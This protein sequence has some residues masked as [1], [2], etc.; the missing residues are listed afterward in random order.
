[1]NIFEEINGLKDGL[2]DEVTNGRFMPDKGINNP[3]VLISKVTGHFDE[4]IGVCQSKIINLD[5]E[6]LR[7]ERRL[8]PLQNQINDSE[9]LI[10]MEWN[11]K[12]RVIANRA[13][14]EAAKSVYESENK[15]R[16]SSLIFYV[17]FLAEFS[18]GYYIFK[19]IVLPDNTIQNYITSV[20]VGAMVLLIGIFAKL[21]PDSQID[22]KRY[23]LFKRI[24]TV[25][26]GISMTVFILCLVQM[27]ETTN[28][29]DMTKT[30]GKVENLN[31]Q[32]L[33][34]NLSL[35]CTIIFG[36]SFFAH[37][38][39]HTPKKL[40]KKRFEEANELQR[41]YESDHFYYKSAS[42]ELY[43]SLE[44]IEKNLKPQLA[45]LKE[46]IS[47]FDPNYLKSLKRK[48]LCNFI[49]GAH[50]IP[51]TEAKDLGRARAEQILK[52]LN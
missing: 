7:L 30:V 23:E 25:L 10:K 11:Q 4:M 41:W 46:Q 32:E 17:L 13:E 9:T 52:E 21:L 33:F 24:N 49:E 42:I 36:S 5:E 22:I 43:E 45:I 26:A 16:F 47:K 6:R 29:F 19:N 1:M 3:D 20:V 27:R 37:W 31:T 12:P 51:L 28:S 44:R 34:F 15:F 50:T 40:L 39:R 35:L 38:H 18:Y 48:A 2:N 8:Q 14:G